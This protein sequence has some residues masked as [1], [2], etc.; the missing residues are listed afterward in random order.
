MFIKTLPITLL[1]IF[2]KLS[3]KYCRSRQQFSR[4][5]AKPY[6]NGL[7]YITD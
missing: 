5:T 2:L 1:Q 3:T 6:I 7:K 4:E